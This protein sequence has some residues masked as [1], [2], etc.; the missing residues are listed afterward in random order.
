MMIRAFAALAAIAVLASA[1][2]AA[3][4][5]AAKAPAHKPAASAPAA[6]KAA[7]AKPAVPAGPFDARNPA[8][9]L[10]LLAAM[11]A[12]GQVASRQDDAVALKISN[13]AYSFSVQYAGCDGQGRA[14]KALAFSGVSDART[15]TLPQINGFN[16]T[17][18]NCHAY[19]D[20]MGKPHAWYSAL[21]F[22]STTREDMVTH[23]GAWQGCWASFG[24]FLKNP[25]AYLAA[26]P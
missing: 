20:N 7:P 11:G 16:Q 14:C 15:A 25:T 13:P 2:G 21:V 5:P 10:A 1:S 8:D 19:Q 4:K 17:S 22:A 23:I 12:Q 18:I 9:L 3:A 24:E 6:A 26:A